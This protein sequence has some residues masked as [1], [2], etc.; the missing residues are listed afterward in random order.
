M[1]VISLYSIK[2]GV[3]KTSTCA[4]LAYLAAKKAKALLIDLDPQGA[5]SYYYKIRADKKLNDKRL[6]KGGKKLFKNIKGSDYP[7]LDILPAD[8]SYRNLDL[9]LDDLKK[10]QKRLKALL[11][12]FSE[13]YEYIFLD[14][15]PN[16]TLLSENIFYASDIILVPIIPTTLSIRTYEQILQFFKDSDL[17]SNK[18]TPFFSIVDKRKKLHRDIMKT[19]GLEFKNSLDS[20]IPNSSDIEKMG[21]HQEPVFQFCSGNSTVVKSF[22]SLWKEVAGKI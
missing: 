14:C 2:G 7:N 13:D 18:L 6:L 16:L 5:A 11:K 9:E 3:G 17:K 1:K 15:P 12:E 20:S 10:S 4:N 19:F 22:N 21:L 8:I